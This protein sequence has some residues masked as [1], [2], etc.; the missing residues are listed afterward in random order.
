[1]GHLN[2]LPIWRDATR[3][4]LTIEEAVRLFPQYHQYTLGTELRQ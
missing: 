2:H 4:R 1:M 3:L